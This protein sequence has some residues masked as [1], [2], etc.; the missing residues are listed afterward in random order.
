MS[1][2]HTFKLVC[3]QVTL[4]RYCVTD[5]KLEN[6]L[7]THNTLHKETVD[8]AG[9]TYVVDVPVNTNIKCESDSTTVYEVCMHVCRRL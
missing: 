7:F 2:G 5:L 4:L 1:T 6:V 3:M 8:H 9:R